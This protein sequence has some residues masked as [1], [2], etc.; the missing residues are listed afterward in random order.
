M[1][2]L[3]GELERLWMM[4]RNFQ[5]VV[6]PVPL[7]WLE[8]TSESASEREDQGLCLCCCTHTISRSCM[9]PK[10]LLEKG[11]Q[12]MLEEDMRRQE[13]DSK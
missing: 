9:A 2:L 3:C 4:W 1:G 13:T 5:H 8:G 12:A 10:I 6:V 11:Q 7:R